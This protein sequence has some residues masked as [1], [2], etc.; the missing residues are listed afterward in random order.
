MK[1]VWLLIED[2]ILYLEI[3]KQI[4]SNYTDIYR[5]TTDNNKL[6]HLYWSRELGRKL[7]FMG[8]VDTNRKKCEALII[9]SSKRRAEKFM[10]R[11]E[12]HLR[13]LNCNKEL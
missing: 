6:Y 12:K 10:H 8:I 2:S 9:S 13:E 1:K 7:Y 4:A 11:F 5:V 3:I